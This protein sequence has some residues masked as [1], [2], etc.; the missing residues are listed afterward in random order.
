MFWLKKVLGTLLMPL[1]LGL[2]LLTFGIL[3]I[4]FGRRWRGWCALLLGWLVLG[5]ASN[6]GVSLVLTTSLQNTY[7]AVFVPGATAPASTPVQPLAYV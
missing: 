6:H 2:G 7:P 5:T 1:P 3:L 4:A